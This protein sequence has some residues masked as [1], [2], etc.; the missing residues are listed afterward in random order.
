MTFLYFIKICPLENSKKVA[1]VREKGS[2]FSEILKSWNFESE[3]VLLGKEKGK[4]MSLFLSCVR[5]HLLDSRCTK[6]GRISITPL[7]I[8]QPIVASHDC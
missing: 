2:R 7:N 8:Q 6:A 4:N 1:R 5:R 3:C